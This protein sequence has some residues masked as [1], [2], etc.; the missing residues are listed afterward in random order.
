M[1][2]ILLMVIVESKMMWPE[3]ELGPD[4]LKTQQ[5]VWTSRNTGEFDDKIWCK[6]ITLSQ[7]RGGGGGMNAFSCGLNELLHKLKARNQ[8]GYP[9]RK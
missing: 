7:G 2:I 9:A 1:A 3:E 5:A 6:A 8:V 4:V